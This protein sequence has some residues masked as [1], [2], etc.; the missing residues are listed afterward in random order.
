MNRIPSL[1]CLVM[2]GL[3]WGTVADQAVA[4]PP[5]FLRDYRF[6]P[7]EST[8]YV[9]GGIADYELKL[10]VAGEFGLETGYDGIATPVST[11]PQPPELEPF[12]K[13]VNVHGILYNPLSATAA[14]TPGWDLDKT[15]NMSGWNGTFS[16]DDPDQLFFLGA[17]GAGVAMRVEATINGGWLH[18]TGGSSDPVG[19]DPVLYQINAL[20]HLL[21]YPDFNGDGAVTAADVVMMQQAL[22]DPQAFESQHDMSADDFLSL[23]D[24]N[25]DGVVNNADLQALIDLVKNGGGTANPVPEPASF[26]LFGLGALAIAIRRRSRWSAVN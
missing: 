11:A 21:P 5:I 1:C 26:V 15:L 8:V 16:A 10:T 22:A 18:L 9:T 20:A 24:V 3:V 7:S 19:S 6:I 23:G 25:S 12:A 13:F 4:D 17:D 14:P 2:S